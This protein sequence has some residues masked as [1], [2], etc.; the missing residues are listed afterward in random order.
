MTD[1]GAHLVEPVSAIEYVQ[2]FRMTDLHR[3][4]LTCRRWDDRIARSEKKQHIDFF[5]V[6]DGDDI[7]NIRY[8]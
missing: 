7:S 2:R 3:E 4:P 8:R 1:F 6:Y 5:A